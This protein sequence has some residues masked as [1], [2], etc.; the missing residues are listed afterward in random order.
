[1]AADND[2]IISVEDTTEVITRPGT[3]DLVH[4]LGF[5][6]PTG[7]GSGAG[8]PGATGP[9]GPTGPLSLIHI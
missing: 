8:S 6:G 1:M 7:D 3:G 5:H 9:T 2:R 4:V